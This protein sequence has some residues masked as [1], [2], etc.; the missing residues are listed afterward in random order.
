MSDCMSISSCWPII[1][2]I[3]IFFC[4]APISKYPNVLFLSKRF[5]VGFLLQSLL[6]LKQ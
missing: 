1:Y 4:L 5:L 2:P 3:L 6:K